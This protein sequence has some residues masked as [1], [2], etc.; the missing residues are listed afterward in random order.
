MAKERARKYFPAPALSSRGAEQ[1]EQE[2]E[3]DRDADGD[4]ED[5][6]TGQPLVADQPVQAQPL[7][8]H[9]I[10]ASTGRRSNRP[11]RPHDGDQRNADRPPRGVEQQQHA[12]A[13]E[14]GFHRNAVPDVEDAVARDQAVPADEQVEGGEAADRGRRRCP[15]AAGPARP[16]GARADTS[17]SR[18]AARTRGECRARGHRDDGEIE[19]EGEGE[20]IQS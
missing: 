9:D 16:S 13:A 1:H 19:H 14:D 4:A 18:A 7:V 8:G 3:A 5:R 15:R 10:P 2:H 12:D 6:F 17:G 20:A 11:G